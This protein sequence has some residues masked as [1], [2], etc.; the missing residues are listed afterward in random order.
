MQV[1]SVMG[2]NSVA[3]D[4]LLLIHPM[5]IAQAEDQVLSSSR[6]D[7]KNDMQEL[8][9]AGFLKPCKDTPDSWEF[10]QVTPT[11]IY[12]PS[13]SP[14]PPPSCCTH[15]DSPIPFPASIWVCLYKMYYL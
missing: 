13:P 10:A 11:C 7:L 2:L 5:S 12:T 9:S 6:Q 15:S 1:A 3:L 8:E 14:T 4:L